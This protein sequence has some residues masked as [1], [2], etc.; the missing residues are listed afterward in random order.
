MINCC[1]TLYHLSSNGY[2]HRMRNDI[3]LTSSSI[4]NDSLNKCSHSHN[5]ILWMISIWCLIWISKSPSG[6][7]HFCLIIALS[8][9]ESCQGPE[10]S[11]PWNIAILSST[12][13]SNIT[14]SMNKYHGSLLKFILCWWLTSIGSTLQ[15][16]SIKIVACV[17]YVNK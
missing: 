16:W 17:P 5:I 2:T 10:S 9:K 14:I 7:V 1:S 6:S 15:I 13:K 3:Y 12:T 11:L 8:C 4:S